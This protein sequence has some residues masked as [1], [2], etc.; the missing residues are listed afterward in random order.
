MRRQRSSACRARRRL[1]AAMGSAAALTFLVLSGA[2]VSSAQEHPTSH[3]QGTTAADPEL[4]EVL[5]G[6][7]CRCGCNLSVYDCEGTMTCD[8]AAA[9]RA[10]AEAMLQEEMSPPQVLSA[11]AADYGEQVLAAPTKSGFNLTA[12][13]LP[14][15]ALGVGGAAVTLAL[16]TWRPRR[17]ARR[18]AEEAPQADPRYLAQ[19]EEELRRED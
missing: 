4:R 3:E 7:M 2:T 6:L 8:V 9:M 12:W 18:A 1:A 11:F 16:R 10:E 17:A 19:V 15:V 13:V 5:T 14:F